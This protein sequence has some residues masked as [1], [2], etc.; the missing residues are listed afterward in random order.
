MNTERIA[1]PD[2][3]LL[4]RLYDVAADRWAP[5]VEYPTKVVACRSCERLNLPPGTEKGDFALYYLAFRKGNEITVLDEPE[6]IWENSLS[7]AEEV[8]NGKAV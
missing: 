1:P 3:G 5:V 6:V 7:A 4:C 8:L 2:S